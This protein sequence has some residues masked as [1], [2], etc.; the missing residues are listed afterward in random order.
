[1]LKSG[2]VLILEAWGN[3]ILWNLGI[4][5]RLQTMDEFQLL[6]GPISAELRRSARNSSLSMNGTYF[7]DVFGAWIRQHLVDEWQAVNVW[8]TNDPITD[9]AGTDRRG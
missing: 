3:R 5:R 6:P 4:H 7:D 9:T 8:L 1:M 2:F